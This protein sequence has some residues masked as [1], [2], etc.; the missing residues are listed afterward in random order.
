MSLR[1]ARQTINDVTGL[2]GALGNLFRQADRTRDAVEGTLNGSSSGNITNNQQL[3]QALRTHEQ[4]LTQVQRLGELRI[5]SSLGNNPEAQR[6]FQAAYSEFRLAYFEA[7]EG[8]YNSTP[9]QERL[10]AAQQKLERDI[11]TI[12][13]GQYSASSSVNQPTAPQASVF[14]SRRAPQQPVIPNSSQP[15]IT[16]Q[17]QAPLASATAVTGNQQPNPQVVSDVIPKRDLG[18][19]F[20]KLDTYAGRNGEAGRTRD[21]RDSVRTARS[22]VLSGSEN[23]SVQDLGNIVPQQLLDQAK[24]SLGHRIR[25]TLGAQQLSNL[26]DTVLSAGNTQQPAG[27]PVAP[28]SILQQIDRGAEQ[29]ARLAPSG[30]SASGQTVKVLSVFYGIA[31]L[32]LLAT[33]GANQGTQARIDR[34]LQAAL[35]ANT[36]IQNYRASS[37]GVGS[38]SNVAQTNTAAEQIALAAPQSVAATPEPDSRSQ[39][40]VVPAQPVAV[41]P[42]STSE[43]V[44]NTQPT[45]PRVSEVSTEENGGAYHQLA[46]EIRAG[47]LDRVR[48]YLDPIAARA[49]V[50]VNELLGIMQ[51][52]VTGQGDGSELLREISVEQLAGS[53][54]AIIHPGE[55]SAD[56]QVAAL[57]DF[58]FGGAAGAQRSVIANNRTTQIAQALMAPDLPQPSTAVAAVP[59][60]ERTVVPAPNAADRAAQQSR[61]DEEERD[62]RRRAN[63]VPA[64]PTSTPDGL[65]EFLRGRVTEA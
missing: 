38:N 64:N 8:N 21:L 52:K 5:R 27:S 55:M 28:A 43:T 60:I 10:F 35:T 1:D 45:S 50:D 36:Q 9:N 13:S 30:G 23:I 57:R 59:A 62:S 16:I 34:M 39:V 12:V 11:L 19:L 4:F 56:S 32:R 61:V 48:T 31:A 26:P 17:P 49:K 25:T 18:R 54:A 15:S 29:I 40:Q 22:Q 6:Q 20:S 46:Q 14:D 63:T 3:Q 41:V 2:V 42:E 24:T 37:N 47:N 7:L 44:A 58:R 33:H 51:A 65:P 53:L